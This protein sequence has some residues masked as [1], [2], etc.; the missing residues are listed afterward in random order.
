MGTSL[1]QSL[2]EGQNAKL[3]RNFCFTWNSFNFLRSNPSHYLGHYGLWKWNLGN[4]GYLG[5]W[6]WHN[7]NLGFWKWHL[8]NLGY[9]GFWQWHDGNLG[10]WKW[11]L[12]NLGF[13]KWN[14]GNCLGYIWIW[15]W[16][17]MKTCGFCQKF[18]IY[19]CISRN[20]VSITTFSYLL[21][22]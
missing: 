1:L 6:Q 14:R 7:G 2:S 15:Q 3:D 16:N 19:P 4:L 13:R 17:R 21:F 18:L 20:F 22:M 11:H 8:G 9:L 12:G 5:L 10:F